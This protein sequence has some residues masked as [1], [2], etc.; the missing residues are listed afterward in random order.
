MP[1][2]LDIP[3]NPP[4]EKELSEPLVSTKDIL[5]ERIVSCGHVTPAGQWYDQERDEWVLLVQ[6]EATLSY[7]D[8]AIV[9]LRSGDHVFIPAHQKHRVERTSSE[10]PCVWVAVHADLK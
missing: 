7:D 5:I 3:V 9:D 1:N 10:P 2:I 6:G 4:R 8:G